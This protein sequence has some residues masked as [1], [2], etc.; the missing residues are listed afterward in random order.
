MDST[1]KTDRSHLG[2]L[3]APSWLSGLVAV[4]AGIFITTGVVVAF[5]LHTSGIQQQLEAWQLNKPQRALTTPDQVLPENDRPGLS[6]TWPL[7]VIWAGVG[8]LVYAVAAT[9]IRSLNDAEELR[10]SLEYVNAKPQERL[11]EALEHLAVRLTAFGLLIALAVA[12]VK[13]VLPYSI[14]AGHA[15]AGDLLSLTGILSIFLSAAV[16]TVSLHLAT[17]LLRLAAGRVRVFS[18][19]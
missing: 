19:N 12:I 14:M 1:A 10:E 3:L 5:S 17:I 6:E 7:V 11:K 16:I 18:S 4:L 8:L 9:I 2:L 13:V 15:A